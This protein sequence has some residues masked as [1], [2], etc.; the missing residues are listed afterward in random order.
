MVCPH[1]HIAHNIGRSS[2]FLS[3]ETSVNL[4]QT[5]C[6][7]SSAVCCCV[8]FLAHQLPYPVAQR[9]LD[10]HCCTPLAVEIQLSVKEFCCQ[11]L[12]EL[13]RRLGRAV[14]MRRLFEARARI[15]AVSTHL[16][17]WDNSVG[18]AAAYGLNDREVGV[19]VRVKARDVF[20][21]SL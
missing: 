15:A 6:W 10:S 19:R 1:H 16:G 5:T 2:L 8:T 3:S 21:H 4:Y 12:N 14:T 11:H 13:E 9:C 17:S 7:Y 18:I 20:P